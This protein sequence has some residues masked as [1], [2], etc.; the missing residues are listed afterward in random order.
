MYLSIYLSIYHFVC[1]LIHV[2]SI[3]EYDL[4]INHY[5]YIVIPGHPY[6]DIVQFVQFIFTS[7][8]FIDFFLSIMN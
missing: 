2:L 8:Y 4:F 6:N 1:L 5:N 3:K 7:R